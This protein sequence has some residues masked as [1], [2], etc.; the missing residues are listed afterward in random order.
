MGYADS[1]NKGR[2]DIV[3][4]ECYRAQTLPLLRGAAC[5]GHEKACI[6]GL[7]APLGGGWLSSL[8]LGRAALALLDLGSRCRDWPMAYLLEELLLML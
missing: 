6:A 8:K 7:T 1:A 4:D 3:R 5:V 2:D